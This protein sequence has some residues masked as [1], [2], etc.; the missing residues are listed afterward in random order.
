MGAGHFGKVLLVKYEEKEQS[1]SR[2]FKQ[3]VTLLQQ[4]KLYAMKMVAMHKLTD[5]MQVQHLFNERDILRHL[6][7]VYM[8]S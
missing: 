2:A 3:V 5:E 7:K 4:D 8:K 1:E 6:W